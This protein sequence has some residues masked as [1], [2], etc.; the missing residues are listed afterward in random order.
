MSICRSNMMRNVEVCNNIHAI[1]YLF[2]YV[3]KGHNRATVEIS[4][5]S[6]NATERNVVEADEI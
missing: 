5:Q 2:K 3:Y 1:K 6:N 4:C